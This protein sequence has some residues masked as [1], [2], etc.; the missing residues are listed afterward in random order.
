[1]TTSF[2]LNGLWAIGA[3]A[4]CLLL[5]ASA[6]RAQ[7][8]GIG[9]DVP[10]PA[11]A[12]DI[13]ASGKGLL[14]PRLDSA[15]RVAIA[16]PP[17][18]LM[19]FQTNFRKGFWYAIGGS[20]V[21]IPSSVTAPADN[22]GNH[23]ATQP[24][25]FQTA[26]GDKILLTTAG[27]G[28]SRISHVGGGQL[29]YYAG[30]S[31]QTG[32]NTGTHR[33]FTSRPGGGYDEHLRIS[34]SG[35]VWVLNS[36]AIDQAGANT[37][38]TNGLQLGGTGSL[39]GLASNRVSGSANRFGLDLYT[40]FE[41][42]LSVVSGGNVGIGTQS[43]GTRLE[44]NGTAYV[45]AENNG[46]VVDEGGQRRVGLMKYA[47]REGG[48]WR[49]INQRFEIGRVNVF[50][51]T[52][53]TGS[54]QF[55]TDLYVGGD[56]RVGV[57]TTAPVE[58]LDVSGRISTD[59]IVLRNFSAHQSTLLA[60]RGTDGALGQPHTTTGNQVTAATGG[61]YSWTW[62]HN[63]GFKPLV[64]VTAE[65][66]NPGSSRPNAAVSYE[67]LDD[68]RVRLWLYNNGVVMDFKIHAVIIR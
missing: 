61:A 42:R 22:L 7:S 17:D 58:R 66:I 45:N 18:G 57:G 55:V 33:F 11:A 21:H 47:G 4:A 8:I 40:N 67:H 38:L 2:T 68:N 9:T 19:V 65:A 13:A 53:A 64:M 41:P 3:G 34:S 1:M 49:A 29:A 16:S 39:S 30:L 51:L 52:T 6:A 59:N 12:L 32:F 48:I 15:A 27:A 35:Q 56:G 46:F 44:V 14:I 54:N 50:D 31:Q 43:P 23:Q 26:D 60:I 25:A 20:W 28:G 63:L 24:L 36:L 5:S 10:H 37:G 62:T